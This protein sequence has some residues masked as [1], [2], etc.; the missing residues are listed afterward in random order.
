MPFRLPG[1]ERDAV[2]GLAI[3]ITAEKGREL[4][5]EASEKKYRALL[6]N[7]VDAILLADFEG[8]S[9]G[10]QPQGRGA[11]RLQPRGAASMHASRLHPA[12]ELP[13]LREVFRAMGESG[14]TLVTH[15]V[16]R[17]DG[18]RSAARSRPR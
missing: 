6:D 4:Q 14:S 15:P 18:S 10:R 3:D 13:R 2:L 12:E 11:A 7:A 9:A 17:K 8:Q 16:I 5:L 1:Q